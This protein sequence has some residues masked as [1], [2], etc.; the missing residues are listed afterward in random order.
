MKKLIFLFSLVS[1]FILSFTSCKKD[2]STTPIS[3]DLEYYVKYTDNGKSVNLKA[4]KTTQMAVSG[5]GTNT[6]QRITS[7][8]YPK[9]YDGGHGSI[10]IIIPCDSSN[11]NKIN[12]DK[13]CVIELYNGYQYDY[14]IGFND[15]KIGSLSYEMSSSSS[16]TDESNANNEASDYYNIIKSITYLESEYSTLTKEK[17][18]W[19][20]LTGEFK[21]S[22]QNDVSNSSRDITGS[23]KIPIMVRSK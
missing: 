6:N 22:V 20:V 11:L 14:K 12:L 9:V 5:Y 7:R 8:L 17:I 19:Y 10:E 2:N 13:K 21:M 4:N 23:Y 18:A 1:V 3:D 15:S 16:G